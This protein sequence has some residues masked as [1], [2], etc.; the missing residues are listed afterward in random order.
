[1]CFGV[2]FALGETVWSATVPALVNA[3]APEH[4]RGRYNSAQTLTW[5]LGATIGPGLAG[6]MI[7][8]GLGMTWAA[9]VGVGCL[10]FALI[11]QALRRGL[12]P[13]QDGLTVP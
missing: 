5:S 4:M 6:A 9:L 13:A 2:V 8:A 3:I 7:G 10:S 1:M 12:T 11:A